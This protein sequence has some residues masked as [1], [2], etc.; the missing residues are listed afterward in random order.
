SKRRRYARPSQPGR[1]RMPQPKCPLRSRGFALAVSVIT[2]LTGLLAQP[3]DAGQKTFILEEHL[4]RTW[5]DQMLTYHFEAESGACHPDSLRL[6]GP[7]G[8]IPVQISQ[9][10]TWDKT[11]FVRSASVSFY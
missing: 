2:L 6:V 7:D 9:F 5:R 11:P 4:N 1:Y 3:A 8:A 10:E